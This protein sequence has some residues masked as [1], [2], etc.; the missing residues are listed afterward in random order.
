ME[1][2]G[3][4]TAR[5]FNHAIKPLS[6][7]ELLRGGLLRLSLKTILEQYHWMILKRA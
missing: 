5:R 6:D 2:N 7:G 3:S 4:V 1:N